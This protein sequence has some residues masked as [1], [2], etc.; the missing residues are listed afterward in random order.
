M[1]NIEISPIINSI[2]TEGKCRENSFYTRFTDQDLE[3]LAQYAFDLNYSLEPEIMETDPE[4][5]MRFKIISK[6]NPSVYGWISRVIELKDGEW[7]E[8]F[9]YG[10][11]RKQAFHNK[12]PVTFNVCSRQIRGIM[13]R[14]L[15]RN[16]RQSTYFRTIF[17]ILDLEPEV[18]PLDFILSWITSCKIQY[19]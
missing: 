15:G 6:A 2:Q 12:Y 16:P 17:G 13:K 19:S 5:P 3:E 1:E 4:H 9:L 7:Q 8:G 14:N 18:S 10:F 11:Y